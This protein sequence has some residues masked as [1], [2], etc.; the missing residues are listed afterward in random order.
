M[1]AR[2]QPLDPLLELMVADRIMATIRA[3]N[4]HKAIDDNFW[5]AGLQREPAD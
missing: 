1:V 2:L 5:L 3:K 4:S